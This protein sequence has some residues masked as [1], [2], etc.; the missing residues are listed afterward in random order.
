M[1]VLYVQFEYIPPPSLAVVG[2]NHLVGA[3]G[4]GHHGGSVGLHY[5]RQGEAIRCAAQDAEHTIR[6]AHRD[7]Q[8]CGVPA[9]PLLKKVKSLDC[10]TA[11]R[12]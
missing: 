1:C 5:R 3:V 8:P 12:G 11:A 10:S 2:N 4:E 9:R 7:R 6:K